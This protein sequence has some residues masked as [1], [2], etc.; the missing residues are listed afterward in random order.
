MAYVVMRIFQT[1]EGVECRQEE[2]PGFRSDIVMQPAN[3][4]KV[5]FSRRG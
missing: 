3:G 1:Y 4:V 2:F 5:A